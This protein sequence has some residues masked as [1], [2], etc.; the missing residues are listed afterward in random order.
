MDFKNLKNKKVL[1]FSV[2]TFG[3]EKEIIAKLNYFGASVDFFDER[4]SNSIFVKG[5]IRLKKNLYKRQIK[6]YYEKILLEIKENFYD[7]LLV[8]RGEVIPQFF[9]KELKKKQQKCFF[10]FYTWY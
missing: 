2:K 7:F 6:K 1:F 8:N 9:L 5:L 4:P 3:I 10:I